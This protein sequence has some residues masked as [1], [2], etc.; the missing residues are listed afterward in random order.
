MADNL[1][2]LLAHGERVRE[3]ANK[4][5][6]TADTLA[7]AANGNSGG[8]IPAPV[9]YDLLGN[10]KVLLWKIREVTEFLPTG[11][12]NSLEDERLTIYDRGPNGQDRDPVKQFAIAADRLE[13]LT[14]LL[15]EAAGAAEGAQ[16]A[17]NGQGWN[18]VTVVDS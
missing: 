13:Q 6:D 5:C 4:A 17:L 7:R 11:V 1:D 12:F 3:A 9:A 16:V 8:V 2:D 14:D 18:E 15:G 10:V